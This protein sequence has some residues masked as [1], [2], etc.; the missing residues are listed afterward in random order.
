[1]EEHRALYSAMQKTETTCLRLDCLDLPVS[2]N[3]SY[4]SEQP[5]WDEQ[6]SAMSAR[7][8]PGGGVG[9]YEGLFNVSYHDLQILN[10]IGFGSCSAVRLIV[11]TRN[12]LTSVAMNLQHEERVWI[13]VLVDR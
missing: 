4:D 2:R 13:I 5:F 10:K 1:M 3:E 12:M 8:T 11:L 9:S 6:V 7:I